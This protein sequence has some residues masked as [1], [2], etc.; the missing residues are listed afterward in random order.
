MAT[1]PRIAFRAVKTLSGLSVPRENFL[2]AASQT[3]KQGAPVALNASGYL[4]ECGTD[5][6]FI[7]GVASRDGQN[8][9]NAGDKNQFVDLAHPDTLFVGNM[10]ASAA[11]SGVSAQ[12]N[13]GSSFGITKHAGSGKWTV[14]T[15]KKEVATGTCRVKVFNFWGE[16]AVGDT[17]GR[18]LFMFDPSFFQGGSTLRTISGQTTTATATDTV[19]TGLRRVVAVVASY[20][21]DPADANDFVSATIGDQAGSPAAGSI[22]IKTWKTADGA[23]VTPVAATAFTKKVNWVATGY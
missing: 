17:L 6:V 10:D 16:D 23:D 13:V 22:I 3:F 5:P 20:D 4:A 15:A 9:T 19:V 7:M 1:A 12:A 11:G 18:V 2:E 14:D 8:G 21:T